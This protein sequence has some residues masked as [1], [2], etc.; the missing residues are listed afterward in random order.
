MTYATYETSLELG[1]P[2]ELYEFVQGLQRWNYI[3]GPDTIVRLG[4]P[5]TPSPIKRD[6]FKQTMDTFKDGLSL[7]FPR[8]DSFA[9]QFLGFAPDL[10]TTVTVLRGHWGDPDEEYQVHWKGRVVGA[11]TSGNEV[12]V[13]CESVFTSI[14]RPGLRARF[15]Y[16]CRHTLY[17]R[18]CGVSRE[19]FKVTGGVLSVGSLNVVIG[20]AALQANGFYTGG[21]LV[22]PSGATRFLTAHVG[23]TVTMS[24][25]LVELYGGMEV[26]IYPG[27]DHLKETCL[28][29]F[30]NLN[31]FGGFPFIPSSNPFGGSSIV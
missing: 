19:N 8:D 26:S 27:C 25:P 21:M 23:D 22:A 4:Q 10:V 28:N 9:S 14:K 11:K 7:T 1:S 30:A 18:G 13:E 24:R 15:E 31:N 12:R 2:V 20:A 6:R 16:T 29:K 17:S 3:S 5:Y